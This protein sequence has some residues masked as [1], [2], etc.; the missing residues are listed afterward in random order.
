[1]TKQLVRK[2]PVFQKFLVFKS[3][4]Q[5]FGDRNSTKTFWS[6]SRHVT[7]VLKNLLGDSLPRLTANM[8]NTYSRIRIDMFMNVEVVANHTSTNQMRPL[9]CNLEESK[10][11][12][13]ESWFFYE[14]AL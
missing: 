4:Q 3:F 13:Y 12:H 5:Q 7:T 1:M 8:L 14:S 6:K 10:S 9:Q 11:G 2:F